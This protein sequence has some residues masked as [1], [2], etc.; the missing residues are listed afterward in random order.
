MDQILLPENWRS[1]K[2]REILGEGAYG[3]VYLAEK[4]I[5]S[6]VSTSAIKIISISPEKN[7]E[8]ALS[9]ELGSQESVNKYYEDLAQTYIQEIKMMIALKGHPNIVY[10]EDYAVEEDLGKS[11]WTIYIRMEYLTPF[12]EYAQTHIMTEE[13]VIHLGTDICTALSA[14]ENNGILHRDIKPSNIFVSEATNLFKLG[15]FGIA[16]KMDRSSGLYTAKGTF[17]YMAPEVCFTRRYDHRADI[18]SLGLVLYLLLN[19]NREPFVDLD[20]QIVYAKDRENATSRRIAGEPIPPPVDASPKMAEV[21]LKAC[22]PEPQRRYEDAEAFRKALEAINIRKSAKNANK[23]WLLWCIPVF[24]LLVSLMILFLPGKKPEEKLERLNVVTERSDNMESAKPMQTI[25]VALISTD[26]NSLGQT[27]NPGLLETS[28]PTKLSLSTEL[29][30]SE[31]TNMPETVEMVASLGNKT[32]EQTGNIKMNEEPVLSI[33]DI[34]HLGIV[35]IM[36]GKR[37]YINPLTHSCVRIPIGKVFERFKET[38]VDLSTDEQDALREDLK[39]QF[40]PEG[41]EKINS[42]ED[43]SEGDKITLVY[44]P[45]EVFIEWLTQKRLVLRYEDQSFVVKTDETGSR[46]RFEPENP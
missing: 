36:E 12:T 13:D 46:F 39:R 6:D 27:D 30:V 38:G 4:Q 37:L 34:S 43:F 16:R 17:P 20:K 45:D 22:D 3:T 1:W 28:E 10:I 2:I 7:E 42:N 29:P 25:S 18:Y 31:D 5:G 35:P 21:V 14:C 40:T 32:D 19:R 9:L 15:D 24:S 23:K 44:C 8:L 11:R 41:N 33:V 26:A